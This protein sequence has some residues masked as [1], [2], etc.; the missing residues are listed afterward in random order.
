MSDRKSRIC[1]GCHI[2]K[3]ISLFY[4]RDTRCKDCRLICRKD[5]YYKNKS[6]ILKTQREYYEKNKDWLDENRREYARKYYYGLTNEQYFQLLQEQGNKCAICG[7][8]NSSN[9]KILDVDHDHKTGIVRGLLCNQC[10]QALGLFGDDVRLLEVAI[11][12]LKSKVRVV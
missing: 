7:G 1:I 4:D 2:E 6:K 8:I 9:K 3:D 11:N 10:N 12:Y 5:Y